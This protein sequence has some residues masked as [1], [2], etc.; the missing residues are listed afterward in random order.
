MRIVVVVACIVSCVVVAC[1]ARRDVSRACVRVADVACG[2][3]Y[4]R[5]A[6]VAM[7]ASDVL[8]GT[9]TR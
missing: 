7:R 9:D 1:V 5:V 3:G 8:D 4:L 6:D 2:R